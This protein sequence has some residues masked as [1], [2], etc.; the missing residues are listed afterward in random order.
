MI[1]YGLT[2]N[3]TDLFGDPYLN[4]TLS[5]TVE[6][7]AVILSNILYDKFGRKVPYLI[8]LG[9]SGL[10]LLSILFVPKSKQNN[11]LV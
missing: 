5:V 3:V 1:Y 2:Y 6:L 4:F 7:F 8:S 9:G 11:F 10:A